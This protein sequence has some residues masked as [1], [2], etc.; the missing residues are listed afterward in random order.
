ML[1]QYEYQMY[2][3]FEGGEGIPKVYFF[4]IEGDFNVL[5]MD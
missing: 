2:K 1:L 4:G 3:N 5:V